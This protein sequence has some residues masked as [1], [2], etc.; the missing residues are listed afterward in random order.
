[1]KDLTIALLS[2]S[3]F[4][5]VVY[6]NIVYFSWLL[7][8]VFPFCSTDLKYTLACGSSAHF[9]MNLMKTLQG[10]RCLLVCCC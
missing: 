6:K 9:M 4:C 3:N 7:P 5:F 1:M 8:C 2:S 10:S